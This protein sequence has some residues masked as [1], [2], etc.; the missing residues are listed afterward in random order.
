MMASL[1]LKRESHNTKNLR[2]LYIAFME[3]GRGQEHFKFNSK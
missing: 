2:E 1:R 3:S